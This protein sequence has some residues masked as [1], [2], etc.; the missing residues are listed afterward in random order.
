MA[1]AGF[2]GAARAQTFDFSY[3]LP[4]FDSSTYIQ[5]SGTL[6][7]GGA[8]GGG[9]QIAGIT[10]SRD[11]VLEGMDNVQA[12]TGLLQPDTAYQADDLVYLTP[13]G[14]YLDL[15]GIT[16]TLAG[17]Y[18]GDDFAG[19][20][21]ISYYNGAYVEPIEGFSQTAGTFTLSPV[22]VPEPATLAVFGAGMLGLAAMRRRTARALR[23]TH[24]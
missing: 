11:F 22:G 4:G 9:Y 18:G 15:Y 13:G 2:S 6:T 23:V 16:F 14:P 12:I 10:G 24:R 19:D 8:S 21:N 20:V 17:G 7:L 1:L 5:A 3:Y